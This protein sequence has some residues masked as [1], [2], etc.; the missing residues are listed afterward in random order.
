MNASAPALPSLKKLYW[1]DLPLRRA[2]NMLGF[3][4]MVSAGFGWLSQTPPNPVSP[5]NAAFD[6]AFMKWAIVGGLGLASLGL[7][8]FLWRH[9][10]VKKVL[11]QGALVEAQLNDLTAYVRETSDQTTGK[12]QRDYTHY[13]HLSYTCAGQPRQVTLKLPGSGFM[14]GLV[15]GKPTEVFVLDSAPLKPLIRAV[16]F[17]RF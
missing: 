13:A 3:G 2:L 11:T 15:K 5:E 7:L 14:Y 4:L 6:T 12:R 10:W 1:S 9:H 8:L 17:N 16:Y